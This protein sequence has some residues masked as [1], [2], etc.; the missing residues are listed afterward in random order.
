MTSDETVETER[1]R[2]RP[3][4]PD[5]LEPLGALHAIPEFWWYPL[6]RAQT[7]EETAAFI[8]RQIASRAERGFGLWAAE[9]LDGEGPQAARLIGWIGLSIPTFLPEILPAVEVGWRLDPAVWGRGLATEGGAASLRYGF[10]VLG[11]DRIVS[12]FEPENE[13]SGRVMTRLGLTFDRATVHPETGDP[14]RVL[15]ITRAAWETGSDRDAR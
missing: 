10:E 11:L 9:L 5:D 1:L 3:F 6:R 14:V 4:R 2:L 7:R 13:A 8:E 12:V 15:A